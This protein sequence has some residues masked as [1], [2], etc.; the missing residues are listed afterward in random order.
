MMRDRAEARGKR[1][2]LTDFFLIFLLLLCVAGA[3][4]RYW[5]MRSG[6]G[7]ELKTYELTAEWRD[8]DY[9]TVSCL[10]EGDLLYT[11]A[12]ETFGEIVSVETVPALVRLREAG[13]LYEGRLPENT[14]CDVRLTV[15]IKGSTAGGVLLR[16]G[17]YPLHIGESYILYTKLAEMHLF[18]VFCRTEPIL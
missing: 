17:V 9:R 6:T 16:N 11:A 4:L 18:V 13:I 7:D 5:G 8:E 12:G 14:R 10:R 2:R 15:R 3:V 1:F